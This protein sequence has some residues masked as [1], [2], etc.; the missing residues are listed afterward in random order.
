MAR[1]TWSRIAKELREEYVENGRCK[2]CGEHVE[3][4][5]NVLKILNTIY[6]HFKEKHVE[7]VEKVRESLRG[8]S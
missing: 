4:G 3:E 2:I 8:A 7:I 5:D 6:R 1:I